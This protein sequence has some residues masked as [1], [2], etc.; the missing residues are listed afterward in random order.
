TGPD[1]GSLP[2]RVFTSQGVLRA[3]WDVFGPSGSSGVRVAVGYAANGNAAVFAAAGPGGAPRVK[4]IEIRSGQT[5]ASFTAYAPTTTAGVWIA[6]AD[7][8]GDGVS[9]I[10]TGAGAGHAPQVKVFSSRGR[11]LTEF[12]AASPSDRNGV[13]VGVVAGRNGQVRIA[14]SVLRNAQGHQST[15]RTT[16]HA[17]HADFKKVK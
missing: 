11:P 4:S 8:T 9:E 7:L 12:G 6:A 1:R 15:V 2:V 14:A 3:S 17:V 13:M 5:L 10:V 16:N